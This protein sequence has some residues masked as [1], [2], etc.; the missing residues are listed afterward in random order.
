MQG[1]NLQISSEALN[2]KWLDWV[3]DLFHKPVTFQVLKIKSSHMNTT[4]L[5]AT[6]EQNPPSSSKGVLSDY[7]IVWI[8]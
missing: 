5:S 1:L 2:V 3:W 4:T 8:S 7:K 6:D